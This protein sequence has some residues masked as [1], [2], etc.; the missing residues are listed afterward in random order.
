MI[1]SFILSFIF[2][3][4]IVKLFIANDTFSLKVHFV[5]YN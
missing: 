1:F 4:D 5:C 2:G 3:Y